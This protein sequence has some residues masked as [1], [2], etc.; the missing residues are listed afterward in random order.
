MTEAKI[1]SEL[2]IIPRWAWILAAVLFAGC[3]LGWVLVGGVAQQET[4]S[5]VGS[6][7]FLGIGFFLGALFAGVVLLTGY[8]NQDAKRR[9][10]RATLWTILV[11]VIPHALGFVAYF[12]VRQPLRSPC[13]GC[14]APVSRGA[15][16]CATC[17]FKLV[18]EAGVE[19]PPAG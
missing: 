5:R 12:L 14:G 10:M 3:V 6:L 4:A 1:G 17:G 13:P 16:Y 7:L 9:G 18:G 11:L 19:K 2:S 8:V 15:S